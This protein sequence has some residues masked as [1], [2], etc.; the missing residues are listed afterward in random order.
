MTKL[1][2][3]VPKIHLQNACFM[4]F[5]KCVKRFLKPHKTHRLLVE[6]LTIVTRF[7]IIFR[8]LVNELSLIET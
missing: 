5:I 1:R 4:E 7:Q 2:N 6:M 8:I 3:F